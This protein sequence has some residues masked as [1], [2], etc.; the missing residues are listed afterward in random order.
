[1]QDCA[2]S[3]E[4][5]SEKQPGCR[6]LDENGFCYAYNSAQM[7]CKDKLLF[8]NSLLPRSREL[9]SGSL[10]LCMLIMLMLRHFRSKNVANCN[11]GGDKWAVSP[12]MS[13]PGIP[14]VH[15]HW[16]SASA[17]IPRGCD[18]VHAFEASDASS[19]FRWDLGHDTQGLVAIANSI[20]W[21]LCSGQG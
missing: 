14:N 10:P 17:V 8:S 16:C 20:A 18:F 9:I 7:W 4:G 6:F 5:G 12:C 3:L 2:Q 21:N 15:K 13:A 1:M 11:D 19:Q